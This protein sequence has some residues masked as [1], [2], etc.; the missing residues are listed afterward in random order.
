MAN[1]APIKEQRTRDLARIHIL[2]KA[3]FGAD[4]DAYEDCLFAVATVRSSADLGHEKRQKLLDH[5]ENLAVRSGIEVKRRT[6]PGR[7]PSGVPRDVAADRSRLMAKIGA[8][9]SALGKTR[10]Y[11]E[12]RML[13]R[14]AGVDK[15]EFATPQ[16]LLKLVAALAYAQQNAQRGAA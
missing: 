5:L 13:R 9:L 15:L 3:I 10:E 11:V 16:S 7:S 8:Q 4:R 1:T 14:I 2:A 12:G 6:P